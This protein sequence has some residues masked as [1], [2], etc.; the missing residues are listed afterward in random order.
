MKAEAQAPV[1]LPTDLNEKA[2]KL[3]STSLTLAVIGWV[4]YI[5]QWCFDLTLGLILA[6]ATAGSSAACGT[7]L[8]VFPFL[9]WLAGIVS[10]HAALSRMKGQVGARRGRAV[11][12]LVL[13][14]VGL[15]FTLLLIVLL[16]VLIGYG[17]HAGW[18]ERIIPHFHK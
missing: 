6:A 1:D 7:I 14:Y 4:I 15:F 13:S 16:A 10:G 9:L 2:N 8:D 3:G 11:W 17:I 18:L 12:G 5:F